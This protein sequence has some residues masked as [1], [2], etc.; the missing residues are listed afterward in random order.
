MTNVILFD[1]ETTGKLAHQ[2]R[3]TSEAQPSL[4]QLAARLE[5]F[6][7]SEPL[8]EINLIIQPA[9]WTIPAEASAIHGI[10]HAKAMDCGVT[11]ANACFLFRDLMSAATIAVAHN[12]DFDRTIM[13]R[14]FFMAEVPEIDWNRL[15]NVC[16]MKA[17]TPIVKIKH[18]RPKHPNDFKW[19]KLEECIRHFFNEP[20][21]GAHD[22]LIDVRACG[23]VYR[24]LLKLGVV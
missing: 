21:N 4:V 11:L 6:D 3:S 5:D 12:I 23:R 8:A 7:T 13:Q 17:A 14:A 9:G 2:E 15:S 20:L 16:T 22:A 19:P 24:E 18:Q 1:T 10:S